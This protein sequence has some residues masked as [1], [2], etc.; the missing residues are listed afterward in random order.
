MKRIFSSIVFFISFQVNHA[1]IHGRV[2]D[3]SDNQ[4]LSG[5]VVS[6][7][8]KMQ[9]LIS[10]ENGSFSFRVSN[11]GVYKLSASMIGY[12]DYKQT[13]I[14]KEKL[15]TNLIIGLTPVVENMETVVIT[16][17]RTEK[18]LKEVPVL[19]QVILPERLKDMGITTIN[20][21]LEHEVPGLNLSQF[22]YRQKVTF[23]GMNA[24]YLLFLVDGERIAGEMDGDVDYNRLNL[25]NVERIEVVR[26]ASSALYGSNA[27]GGVINI[28]TK[29][30][31]AALNV[32]AYSKISDYGD[33]SAGSSFGIKKSK[34][35]SHT[36]I[37]F[38]Q[39]DGYLIP[40][41]TLRSM[42]QDKMKSATLNQLFDYSFTEKLRCIANGNFFY[43]RVYDGSIIPAH[44]AYAGIGGYIKAIY[45][46]DS[47]TNFEITHAAD[48]YIAYNVYFKNNNKHSK[49]STDW[50]QNTRLLSNFNTLI[51][52]IVLGIEYKTENI[53]SFRVIDTTQEATEK[54]AFIQNDYKI[55]NYFSFVT[56]ARATYHSHYGFNAVPKVSA[57]ASLGSLIL[58]A[59]FGMGYRSPTLKEMYYDFEHMGMFRLTGNPNLKPERSEYEG[60]SME[61]NH[62]IHNLSINLYRNYVK[63]MIVNNWIEP[64]VGQYVNIATA[65]ILGMD[66]MD[67]IVLFKNFQVN[68][69]ISIVDAKNLETKKQ[70]YDISPISVNGN[71][72]YYFTVFK[73]K[74]SVEL[75]GKYTGRRYYE[76]VGEFFYEDQPYQTWRFTYVQHYKNRISASVGIDN[77]F[78]LI[79]P[80]SLGNISPGRR[81]FVSLNYNFVKY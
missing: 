28:I 47:V 31:V 17:T 64:K 3:A 19:T 21:A 43:N 56:G 65:Q 40:G 35:R 4:A 57:M 77:I 42:T 66:V 9:F 32:N 1:Q 45:N 38:K 78:N 58:R 67:K 55:N 41:D 18:R 16:G 13:I 81:Y 50:Q 33:F 79:E 37:N 24:K 53:Y 11:P 15:D 23:Q 34:I 49:Y 52:N 75:F 8:G 62:S 30:Q 22:T 51:G 74:A 46:K 14:L 71:A 29:K 6:I 44:H 2:I 59:S 10:A 7:D 76:P 20:A 36:G 27:I 48:N 70:I 5:V 60:F 69:G 26:G 12:A 25:D 63:D 72:R 54:T 68:G 80:N 61:I 73:E 39:T